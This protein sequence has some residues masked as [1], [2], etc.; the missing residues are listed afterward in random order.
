[1][2]DELET[3]EDFRPHEVEE[4]A[5]RLWARHLEARKKQLWRSI[6]PPASGKNG[7]CAPIRGQSLTVLRPR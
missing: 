2:G 4:M 6:T 5:R 3:G 7:H 1:L